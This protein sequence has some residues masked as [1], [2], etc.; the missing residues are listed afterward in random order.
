[1]FIVRLIIANSEAIELRII[2]ISE[3]VA[4]APAQP[5]IKQECPIA[6]SQNFCIYLVVL[7]KPHYRI[8]T[9]NIT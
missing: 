7:F 8:G 9:C 6:S 4:A 1:M 5:T 2:G 3:S